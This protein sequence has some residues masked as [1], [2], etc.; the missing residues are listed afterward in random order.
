MIM[1]IIIL[2]F[3]LSFVTVIYILFVAFLWIIYKINGG[4]HGVIW[5]IV[6]WR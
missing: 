1:A 5:Y 4:K 3:L 6:N 2:G